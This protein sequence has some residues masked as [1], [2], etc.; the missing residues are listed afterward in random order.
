MVKK[1]IPPP[2][3]PWGCPSDIPDLLGDPC[4][5][6]KAGMFPAEDGM[7]LLDLLIGEAMVGTVLVPRLAGPT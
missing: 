5:G 4:I 3:A 1:H 6:D 7:V 2:T